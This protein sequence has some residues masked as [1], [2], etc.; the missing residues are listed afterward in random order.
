MHQSTSHRFV[1]NP[2]LF[3]GRLS[4]GPLTDLEEAY[5]A[6]MSY[7]WSEFLEPDPFLATA[8]MTPA[9]R[10]WL[11]PVIREDYHGELPVDMGEWVR[12]YQQA[13]GRAYRHFSHWWS[14]QARDYNKHA[15]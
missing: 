3:S 10:L 14:D 15:A 2:A 7:E 12:L 13:H 1:P 5:Q 6:L 9:G 4:L 8:R 11:V